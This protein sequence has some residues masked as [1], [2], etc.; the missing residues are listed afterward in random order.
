MMQWKIHILV[1][2]V[3]YYDL[4]IMM[5]PSEFIYVVHILGRRYGGVK[6][7]YTRTAQ[8]LGSGW[9]ELQTDSSLY[10]N[11]SLLLNISWGEVYNP[12]SNTLT[13]AQ[14]T[15]LDWKTI[16]ADKLMVNDS[17]FGGINYDL[18]VVLW[19]PPPPSPSTTGENF[20]L[21][22]EQHEA[23]PGQGRARHGNIISNLK[24]HLL[25]NSEHPGAG[26]HWLTGDSAGMAT[27]G[28]FRQCSLWWPKFWL[29]K[30]RSFT[31]KA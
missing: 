23:G 15:S 5:W 27:T 17:E 20:P 29:K 11:G 21:I 9:A 14:N 13:S 30:C 10:Q 24:L 19:C 8:Y 28:A 16:L 12:P 2:R 31:R 1:F 18:S 7:C 3:K 6:G 26:R 4:H 22:P 25:H